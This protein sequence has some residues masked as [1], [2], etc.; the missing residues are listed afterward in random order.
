MKSGC[1]IK[2]IIVLTIL[3]AAIMYIIQHRSGL[4]LE[5]GKKILTGFIKDDLDK[6]FST[7]K[8][9][10]EK[11][12]LKNSLESYLKNLKAENIPGNDDLNR[13][14]DLVKHAVKDS[15]ITASELN[16]ISNNLKMKKSNERPE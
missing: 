4:F 10:P 6:E 11:T 13:I 8:D 1:F 9:S 3:I 16:E 7:V 2:S 5:P 14:F 12:E 15:V